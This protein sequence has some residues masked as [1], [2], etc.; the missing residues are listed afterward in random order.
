MIELNKK[1]SLPKD[2][3]AL[4]DTMKRLKECDIINSTIHE[5]KDGPKIE[6]VYKC[7]CGN[8][9]LS[10]KSIIENTDNPEMGSVEIVH[11]KSNRCSL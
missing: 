8:I 5:E 1:F 2:E 10:Q 4:E 11:M 3:R 6:E 7:P 9:S